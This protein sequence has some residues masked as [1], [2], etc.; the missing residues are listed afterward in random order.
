[1][2]LR[3]LKG[4]TYAYTIWGL[5]TRFWAENMELIFQEGPFSG[6][7]PDGGR[8]ETTSFL[9]TLLC[10]ADFTEL[11]DRWGGGYV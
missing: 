3:H 4:K 5:R 1:M 10:G 11:E 2:N 9:S 6:A 8:Q 7:P